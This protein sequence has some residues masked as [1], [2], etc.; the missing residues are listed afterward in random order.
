MFCTRIAPSA[1]TYVLRLLPVSVVP[2]ETALAWVLMLPT[3]I[4]F[5]VPSP[6][7]K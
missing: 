7:L 2:V 6:A 3:L 4:V 1:D 5:G